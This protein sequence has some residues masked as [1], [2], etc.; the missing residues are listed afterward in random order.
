MKLSLKGMGL[1]FGILWAFAVAWVFLLGLFWDL[2]VPFAFV[3]HLYFGWFGLSWSGMAGATL[4]GL[5]DGAIGGVAFAW[6]YNRF[7]K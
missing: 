2:T 6:L 1:A 4:C 3:H 5:V 7:A